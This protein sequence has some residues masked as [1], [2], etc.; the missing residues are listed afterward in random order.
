MPQQKLRF[1]PKQLEK[2]LFLNHRED[3][4]LIDKLERLHLSSR[5]K[6]IELDRERIKVRNELRNSK[7][8]QVSVESTTTTP[9]QDLKSA[10][11]ESPR[12]RTTLQRSQSVN[13]RGRSATQDEDGVN[14][15]LLGEYRRMSEVIPSILSALSAKDEKKSISKSSK[16]LPPKHPPSQRDSIDSEWQEPDFHKIRKVVDSIKT[17][18]H[19]MAI[20]KKLEYTKPNVPLSQRFKDLRMRTSEE[21]HIDQYTDGAC[22]LLKRKI[23]KRRRESMSEGDMPA[24]TNR[25]D[26]GGSPDRSNTPKPKSARSKSICPENLSSRQRPSTNLPTLK[27]SSSVMQMKNPSMR[28]HTSLGSAAPS[29]RTD[30]IKLQFIDEDELMRRKRVESEWD[31]Y[32]QIQHKV[33]KFLVMSKPKYSG[34]PEG[35]SLIT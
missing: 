33:E 24:F 23:D 34:V 4:A 6:E 12:P 29:P 11:T 1:R 22:V 2:V 35:L 19:N 7:K 10:A 8:K 5:I 26:S 30:D 16:K 25:R 31:K 20:N 32:H 14:A 21:D 15:Y 17:L 13:V 3:Q 27:R 28:S 9:R 18:R